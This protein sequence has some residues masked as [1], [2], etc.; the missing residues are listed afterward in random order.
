MTTFGRISGRAIINKPIEPRGNR[1]SKP[2]RGLRYTRRK[3]RALTSLCSEL[4]KPFRPQR[5]CSGT[6][7][8]TASRTSLHVDK[9]IHLLH[10]H[11]KSHRAATP[12]RLKTAILLIDA[13]NQSHKRKPSIFL[14]SKGIMQISVA[15]LLW[16]LPRKKL[17]R[18]LRSL[19][20]S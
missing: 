7:V 11:N 2:L 6:A 14:S 1:K 4:A 18:P 5:I 10:S 17:L 8:E 3:T 15:S 9:S 12:V 19:K 20:T 13:I 16:L